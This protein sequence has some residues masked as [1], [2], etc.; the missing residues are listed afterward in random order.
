MSDVLSENNISK[1]KQEKFVKDLNLF[2][3]VKNGIR[4]K[5]INNIQ[6]AV[7]NLKKWC[8][9]NQLNIVPDLDSNGVNDNVQSKIEDVL[10]EGVS[11][12]FL[13]SLGEDFAK[14]SGLN[15]FAEEKKISNKLL[16]TL[17]D[18]NIDIIHEAL[19]ENLS[20]EEFELGYQIHKLEN[21]FLKDFFNFFINNPGVDNL[22]F[23]ID[24]IDMNEWR[25]ITSISQ[26][27]EHL[28]QIGLNENLKFDY[29]SEA[30]T[31]YN[32]SNEIQEQSF[33]IRDQLY[34]S[35]D[36]IDQS[37]ENLR[38]TAYST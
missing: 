22:P 36:K 38:L 3:S 14:K 34:N 30:V 16:Q 7:V 35:I 26:F 32:P 27:L 8:N 9:E 31:H 24:K 2:H 1:V 12:N 11:E 6:K 21:S 19:K 28:S 10:N 25:K 5:N 4:S 37:L 33:Q 17:K 13:D 23:D 18:I 20:D 15:D 29:S